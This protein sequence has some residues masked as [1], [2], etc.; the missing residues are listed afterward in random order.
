MRLHLEGDR[1]RYTAPTGAVPEE[2]RAAVAHWRADLVAALR[3]ASSH[4]GAPEALPRGGDLVLSFAQQ[5]L[6][7]LDQ[8]HGAGAAY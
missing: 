5:R 2:I 7:F 3:T 6:W 1:L 4:V 8:L